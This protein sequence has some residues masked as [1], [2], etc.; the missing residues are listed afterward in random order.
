MAMMDRGKMTLKDICLWIQERFAYFRT[1]DNWN[2]SDFYSFYVF[3]IHF[4]P[5]IYFVNG[6]GSVVGSKAS[7]AT[8]TSK[9]ICIYIYMR[10]HAH[11]V[12]T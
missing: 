9:S 11:Y 4:W 7:L 2:V 12:P 5:F 6:Y 1:T 10:A 3:R 8:L